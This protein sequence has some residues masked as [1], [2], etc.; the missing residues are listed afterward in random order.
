[1]RD[2]LNFLLT[3]NYIKIGGSYGIFEVQRLYW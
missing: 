3:N 2:I 1:M